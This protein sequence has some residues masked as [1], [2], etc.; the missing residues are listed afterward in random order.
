MSS[1]QRYCVETVA[2]LLSPL[3]LDPQTQML[4][5][6]CYGMVAT[7]TTCVHRRDQQR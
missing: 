1:V 6:C 4:L 2:D 7:Y 3:H 5:I